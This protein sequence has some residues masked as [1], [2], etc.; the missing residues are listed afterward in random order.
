[1]K[2]KIIVSGF[3]PEDV[4]VDVVDVVDVPEVLVAVLVA[5]AVVPVSV[6]IV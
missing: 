4:W 1:M 2:G 3:V 5:A 6:A